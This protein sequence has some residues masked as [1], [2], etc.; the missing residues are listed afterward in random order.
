MTT[1]LIPI[2]LCLFVYFV[3]IRPFQYWTRR[4]VIQFSVWKLWLENLKMF[5][6]VIPMADSFKV[7]YDAFPG[8]RYCGMYQITNP[9][10]VIKDPELIKQITV[11]DFEHF[12]DHN[13]FIS[14]EC[15]PLWAKNLFSLK[16]ERWKEMR[17]TLTPSFTSS[18]MKA[19]FGIM[20]E[21]AEKFVNHFKSDDLE[22]ATVEFYDIFTRFTND[23]IASASFGVNCDSLKDRDN[24]FYLMGKMATNFN[25]FWKNLSIAIMMMSPKLA[26]YL[27]VRVFD[28]KAS[29]FLRNLVIGNM[30]AREKNGIVRPDMIH[31]LI[32][33]RK[34]KLKH[35]RSSEVIDSGF[36]VIEESE[37][38]KQEE[39]Q[40]LQLTDDYVAAQALV[41]FFA[42][43]ETVAALMSFAGYELAV[44]SFV[45]ERLQEEVDNVLREGNG[46]LTYEALMKM[47]YL[48]MVIS[49]TL[50]KWPGAVVFDRLC[51]K[52]YT[53]QPKSEDEKP[54]NIK[55]GDVVMMVTYGMHMDEKYFPNPD[56]FDP[57]RFNKENRKNITPYT[58]MPFG[59]G[60]RSCI[61]NRFALLEAKILIFNILKH[62]DIIVVDKSVIPI[63]LARKHIILNAEKGFWF[64]LK[65]RKVVS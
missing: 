15:E 60:P 57:E 59:L 20:A 29:S 2:G 44:D 22:I 9:I 48:D 35:K 61:G 50:R 62:F 11:K 45:Q 46:K 51:V 23:V 64:G 10:L 30:E 14:E 38:G 49:E 37:I 1:F 7:V 19:M 41:F 31:L 39:R 27:G 17:S 6:Q 58:Y 16:G 18:K 32:E 34:G 13:Q 25:G 21:C 4:G 54:F 36:A 43:F 63:K 3:L 5:L 40:K 24:E 55:K 8:V 52:P 53:I 56:R 28:E 65:P 12:I 26:N 42:G 33:A 47:E